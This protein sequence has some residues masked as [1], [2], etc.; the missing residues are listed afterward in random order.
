[1][2]E[3][4]R[5]YTVDVADCA[6]GIEVMEK[7]LKKADKVGSSRRNDVMSRVETDD[8]GL[9][10]DGW[11]VYLEWDETND[12]GLIPLSFKISN[13]DICGQANHSLKQNS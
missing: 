6:G 13:S 9:S 3:E 7:V 11:S 5:Y 4:Q 12:S 8:G 10:V 2:P 1:M